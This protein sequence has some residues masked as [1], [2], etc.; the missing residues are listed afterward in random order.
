MTDR[1]TL[2]L[3]GAALLTTAVPAFAHET[4]DH[5]HGEFEVVKT[6][7]EWKKIL[8]P[9]QYMVLREEK[10]E[11]AFTSPLNDNKAAGIYHCA[12][13]DNPLYSSATK[14]DSGTGW[15][16]FWA[17]IEGR[18]GTKEDRSWLGRLRIE[19]HCARCGGHQGHV[20]DDGPAPTGKRHCI[21]GIALT[22]RPGDPTAA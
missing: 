5:D 12:G 13:C 22:F 2:L 9:N 16:S 6:P 8:T 10:T 18:V 20:F 19:V 21:N 14:F 15:P 17:P 3:S 4:H 1:R 7:E 11:R